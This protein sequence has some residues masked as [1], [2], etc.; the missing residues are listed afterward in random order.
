M[1]SAISRALRL[2]SL[3]VVIPGACLVAVLLY[4]KAL[5]DAQVAEASLPSPDEA[6]ARLAES[7]RRFAALTPA[8]HLSIAQTEL[9]RGF[10]A[11]TGTGGNY[12]LAAQHLNVIPASAPEHG[13]AASLLAEV[14]R[15]R[16][17]TR[18]FEAHRR[19]Q[20]FAEAARRVAAGVRA[21]GGDL[22]DR[23]EALGRSLDEL[24]GRGL[25]CVHAEG[26]DAELLTFSLCE[27]DRAMLDR[28]A[29]TEQREGLR[30]MGFRAIR[31]GHDG[32][33]VTLAAG[34]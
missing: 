23:R 21:S 3:I 19:E 18:E 12:E 9:A 31:C 34:R 2:L 25:G 16:V 26:D 14:A 8:Q 32:P 29:P 28:V 7:A 5:T 27:C 17:A 15:R 24:S 6:R 33:S 13:L 11:V 20:L 30:A 10:N 4:G 22:E 1:R